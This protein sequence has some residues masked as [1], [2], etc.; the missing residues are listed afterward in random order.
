[1]VL[2]A[3]K[4]MVLLPAHA[5][6]AVTAR[7]VFELGAGFTP[8][9]GPPDTGRLRVALERILRDPIPRRRAEAF[10]ARYAAE[11]PET[12]SRAISARIAELAA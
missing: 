12:V 6:Q 5:E 2:R 9:D 10:A 7:N 11:D 1:M 4:P 8:G 3:G